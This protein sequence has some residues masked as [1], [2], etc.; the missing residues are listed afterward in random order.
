MRGRRRVRREDWRKVLAEVL[1]DAGASALDLVASPR[2]PWAEALTHAESDV[3]TEQAQ[4]DDR[5]ERDRRGGDEDALRKRRD[6]RA[7]H[8]AK[9]E[10]L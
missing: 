1:A 8:D 10:R 9:D 7:V 6:R 3:R 5:R 4:K 2:N